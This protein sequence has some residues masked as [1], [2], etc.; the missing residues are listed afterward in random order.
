MSI[1]LLFVHHLTARR[2]SSKLSQHT[3]TQPKHQVVDYHTFLH[4]IFSSF[5][6]AVFLEHCNG[7][8]DFKVYIQQSI[9]S[10]TYCVKAT[11]YTIRIPKEPTRRKDVT[12]RWVRPPNKKCQTIIISDMIS[13]NTSNSQNKVHQI[14]SK[15]NQ[16]FQ[17]SND[18]SQDR[19]PRRIIK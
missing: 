2:K 15:Y 13:K 5:S 10:K 7:I 11:H 17:R 12:Q 18:S 6:Y 1:Y 16:N 3:E 19:T 4:L 14:N 8:N 9:Q